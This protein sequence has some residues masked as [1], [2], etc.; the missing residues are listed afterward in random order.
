MHYISK[1]TQ[2]LTFNMLP[3]IY[4][5]LLVFLYQNLQYVVKMKQVKLYYVQVN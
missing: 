1:F 2:S 3:I 4:T 5:H